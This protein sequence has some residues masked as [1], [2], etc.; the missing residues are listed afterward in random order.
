MNSFWVFVAMSQCFKLGQLRTLLMRKPWILLFPNKTKQK[1]KLLQS[2]STKETELT[3]LC[4]FSFFST[5]THFVDM[6]R[7]AI[8]NL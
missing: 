4:E 6:L 7:H 1:A 8:L 2:S 5:R 3:V